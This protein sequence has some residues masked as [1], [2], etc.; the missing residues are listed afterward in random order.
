MCIGSYVFLWG[1]KQ[2][3]TPTWYGIF[4][5]DGSE[6]EVMDVL[7]KSWSGT[8]PDNRAP[9]ITSYTLNKL[10]PSASVKLPRKS[11]GTVAIEAAD[12]EGV[13][14]RYRLEIMPESTDIRSGGDAESKP[15][16]IKMA[17]K[18]QTEAPATFSFRSP[19]TPGP[20]RLFIY[21]YDDADNAAVANILFSSNDADYANSPGIFCRTA[22][23]Q[24]EE[25]LCFA[26]WIPTVRSSSFAEPLEQL[27]QKRSI[28]HLS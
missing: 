16:A 4:L 18:K 5:E 6:T 9:S 17:F 22:D 28:G 23:C 13:N 26:F 21:A 2:E 7:K 14:L 24:H 25:D 20:Y 1:Q 10:P 27:R 12:P 3:T 15:E 8:W 19:S 11:T